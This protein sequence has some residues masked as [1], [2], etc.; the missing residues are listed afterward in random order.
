MPAHEHINQNQ[1]SYRVARN[2]NTRGQPQQHR[3]LASHPTEGIIGLLNFE[4]YE[5]PKSGESKHV[6]LVYTKP[7]FRKQGIGSAMYNIASR[8]VGYPLAHDV[9]RSPAGNRF[10]ISTSGTGKEGRG[11]TPWAG[12]NIK[13]P[14]HKMPA[15]ELPEHQ[16]HRMAEIQSPTWQRADKVDPKWAK[17]LTPAKGKRRKGKRVQQLMLPGTENY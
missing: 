2:T 4:D 11:H 12:R 7:A 16:E 1:I 9:V 15:W 13:Q 17:A 10:A 5:K 6:G 8:E 14:P 3:V